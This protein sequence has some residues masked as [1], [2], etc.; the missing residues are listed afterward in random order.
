MKCYFLFLL[1]NLESWGVKC[2][3]VEVWQVSFCL[4]SFCTGLHIKILIIWHKKNANFSIYF[5]MAWRESKCP[6]E[7]PSAYASVSV[8]VNESLDQRYQIL[9]DS[10]DSDP[11]I[12]RDCLSRNQ[13]CLQEHVLLQTKQVLW[14]KNLN[15]SV[16]QMWI[17]ISDVIN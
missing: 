8:S 1:Q 13:C 15:S 10:T 6:Q 11:N 17:S 7:R 12:Y 2:C 14:F 16:Y 9:I 3:L 4:L 5:S